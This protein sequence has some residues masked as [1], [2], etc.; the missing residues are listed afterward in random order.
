MI[1][2]F[3]KTRQT[4]VYTSIEM[5]IEFSVIFHAIKEQVSKCDHQKI[6]TD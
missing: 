1:E 2:G 5:F 6:K 4:S 3:I